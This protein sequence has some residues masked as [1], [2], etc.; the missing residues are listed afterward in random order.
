ML[1][2]LGDEKKWMI[3][4]GNRKRI[5]T[6]GVMIMN[7]PSIYFEE[8]RK[9]RKSSVSVAGI[10]PNVNRS[11]ES[12]ASIKSFRKCLTHIML[13]TFEKRDLYIHS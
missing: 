7:N 8:L 3:M 4:R 2:L 9:Y 10:L 6:L 12:P 1:W 11:F 13:P 5:R